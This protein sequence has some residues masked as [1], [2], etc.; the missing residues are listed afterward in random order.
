MAA[1][2]I[3][4]WEVFSAAR[5][6]AEVPLALWRALL[7]RGGRIAPIAAGDVHSR[8]AAA[9]QRPATYVYA[10]ERSR[11]GVLEALAQRRLFASTGEPLDFVVEHAAGVALLGETVAGREW[12]PRVAPGGTLETVRI[13]TNRSAVYAVRRTAQGTLAAVSAPIWI[14]TS[15]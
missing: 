1:L 5:P 12:S 10:R 3:D 14:D 8:A 2:A 15:H 9:R 4:G 6:H 13:D 11:A 7:R